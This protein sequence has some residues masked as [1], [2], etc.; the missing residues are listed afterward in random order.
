MKFPRTRRLFRLL[1]LR[2]EEAAAL[3]SRQFEQDLPRAEHAAVAVHLTLCK[4]C[5]RYRRQLQY[6]HSLFARLDPEAAPPD[7]ASCASIELPPADR[8][9]IINALRSEEP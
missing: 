3:V 5:S 2:C 6:L 9:R 7:A 4:G 1:D 8:E